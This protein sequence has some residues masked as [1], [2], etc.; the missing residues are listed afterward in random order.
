VR[1]TIRLTRASPSAIALPYATA[2]VSA[3]APGDYTAVSGTLTFAPG[4]T[5]KIVDVSIVSDAEFELDETFTLVL[6]TGSTAAV[7]NCRIVNDDRQ[8]PSRSRSVRH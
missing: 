4:E 2:D 7:G 6:G 3:V 5:T 8:P 1:F